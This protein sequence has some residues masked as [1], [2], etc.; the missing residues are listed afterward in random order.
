MAYEPPI[1]TD[2][3]FELLSYTPPTGTEAD[4][5]F[6]GA[7]PSERDS[8]I[9]GKAEVNNERSSEITGSGTTNDR[10][11]EITGKI[12][13]GSERSS[14]IYGKRFIPLAR[15][16]RI[17][18]KDASGEF[19]GEFESF[20]ALKFGKRL[21]NYG[22]CSFE[23]PANDPKIASL[24]SLRLY[25]VWIYMQENAGTTL[26]WA[27]EQAARIGSL[28]N[29]GNNWCTIQ[30]F[31]WLEQLNSRYT[32][33]EKIF[34]NEDQ[35]D[36]AWQLIDETQ[37]D[38]D[39]GDLG[40]TQGTIEE[41]TPRDKTFQNQN[42]MSAILSLSDVV[43]GFDFEITHDK[44]FNVYSILGQDKTNEIILEYGSNVDSCKI[45]EDFT[46]PANRAI[47]L[48]EIIGE[49][50]LQR[51]ER[52]DTAS[53]ETYG[54]REYVESESEPAEPGTFDDRGDAVNRKYGVPL[55]KLDLRMVR[56]SNPS[57]TQFGVGDVIGVKIVGG[58]YNINE[59]YRVFEWEIDFG[60]DNAE[61]LSLVLGKFTI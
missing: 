23:V 20:R 25:T 44:V 33:F 18:V 22:E 61:S 2:A 3:N 19:I 51:V 21:N 41:T 48:G 52:D 37:N 12:E 35:G 10:N 56:G 39:H 43:S 29:E 46:H 59:D 54:L 6:S 53:Q 8:E 5:D 34:E 16:Y 36:I 31:D 26:V 17:L 30:C 40:I 28:S 58:I 38:G 7:I 1:G 27:G 11:S 13:V 55:I 45:L 14:E 57:I 32:V 4:F 60:E 24:V 50:S 42:I 47:I 15:T 49:D 9:Q